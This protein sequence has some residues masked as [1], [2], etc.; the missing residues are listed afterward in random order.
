GATANA[1]TPAPP[2]APLLIYVAQVSLQTAERDIPATLDHVIDVA[3]SLGGYL[4]GRTDTQVQ[5]RIPSNRFREGL[6]RME[7]LGEVLHRS[8]TAEDVSE[9]F[10]D[11]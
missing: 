4:A 10:H 8:V 5:V 3:Q 1:G 6:N 2:P 9:E 7:A 11:V